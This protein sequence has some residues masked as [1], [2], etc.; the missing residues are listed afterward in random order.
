MNKLSFLFRKRIGLGDD[1]EINFNKLD[2]ILEKTAKNIPF[3]NICII[4]NKAKAI[5][6]EN[7]VSKLLVKNEGGLCY[8]LNS[9]L[10]LFLLENGFNVKV[11]RGVVYDHLAQKYPTF[12]RTHV[13]ILLTHEDVTYLIDTG[14]GA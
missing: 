2:V 1:E 8:E 10:Y 14:F 5:S 12:G 9:L 7:L 11:V 4:E 13:T 3:E 6:R